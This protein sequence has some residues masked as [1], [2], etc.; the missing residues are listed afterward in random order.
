MSNHEIELKDAQ[1]PNQSQKRLN[2][3]SQ[4][5]HADV[6]YY[7]SVHP[8]VPL[9]IVQYLKH[10][11]DEI[12]ANAAAKKTAILYEKREARNK[13]IKIASVAVFSILFIFGFIYMRNNQN[14]AHEE[15]LKMCENLYL[16]LTSSPPASPFD[17]TKTEGINLSN[18]L[19]KNEWAIVEYEKNKE[20]LARAREA[21]PTVYTEKDKATVSSVFTDYG[22]SNEELDYFI[23]YKQHMKLVRLEMESYNCEVPEIQTKEDVLVPKKS[24]F[25]NMR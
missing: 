23:E 1:K 16:Q 5:V 7:V 4:S 3:L 8:N 24:I 17:Q 20:I 15:Q 9:S 18:V 25:D 2:E 21:N 22:Y 11:S 12:V 14:K 10:D 19:W 6:R 13:A